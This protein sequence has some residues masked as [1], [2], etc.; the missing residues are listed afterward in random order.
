MLYNTNAGFHSDFEDKHLGRGME[1]SYMKYLYQS[2]VA[3]FPALFRGQIDITYVT[4]SSL[5]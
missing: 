1:R 3:F 4:A 5:R 2:S